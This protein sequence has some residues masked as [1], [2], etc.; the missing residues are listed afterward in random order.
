MC[1]AI[2]FWT[3][4]GLLA[5]A[6]LLQAQSFPTASRAG[7]LSIGAGYAVA[8]PDYGTDNFKG[9]T[10]YADFDFF[11]NLGVELNF[12]FLKG[13]QKDLYE[14]TYE[15]GVRYH[16]NYGRF[17]PYGKIMIGRGV[18]NYQNSVANLAYNMAAA[19]GGVD[20]KVIKPYITVRADAEYQ[21]WSGF[22]PNGLTPI[23][24]YVGVAY[25]FH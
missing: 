2:R 14:K 16:R 7:D 11:H 23:V 17:A 24:G 18:F 3:I 15:A 12:R 9:F 13:P 22:P 19:G 5:T 1:V 4:V 8:K 6:S 21:R 25:H 20:C 10:G